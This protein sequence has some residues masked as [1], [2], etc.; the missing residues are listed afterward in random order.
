MNYTSVKMLRDGLSFSQNRVDL[1][2]FNRDI[3]L[4]GAFFNAYPAFC[5]NG[6][7]AIGIILVD[8]IRVANQFSVAAA[9]LK[10]PDTALL[11]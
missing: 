6:C 10:P 5:A 4:L 2:Q 3:D 11:Q 9:D 7:V 1:F 8:L